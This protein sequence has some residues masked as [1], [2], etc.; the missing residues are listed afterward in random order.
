MQWFCNC[1]IKLLCLTFIWMHEY[2]GQ[3]LLQAWTQWTG[4][5]TREKNIKKSEEN[6][7]KMS[8]MM[9]PYKYVIKYIHTF[10]F[11]R[12]DTL[13][14]ICSYCIYFFLQI[15]Q[16]SIFF[17]PI[18]VWL[19]VLP[20][21]NVAKCSIKRISKNSYKCEYLKPP[22]Q[23]DEYERDREGSGVWEGRGEPGREERKE[24]SVSRRGETSWVRVGVR[25]IVRKREAG[26]ILKRKRGVGSGVIKEGEDGCE[27]YTWGGRVEWGMGHGMKKGRDEERWG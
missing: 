3:H 21:C 17:S 13:G 14:K 20:M 15:Y 1:K 25:G 6:E 27:K 24:A 18:S 23:V 19:S 10:S 2:N 7:K 8:M 12:Q 26:R 5:G 16:C 11:R 4:R 9:Y 22:F